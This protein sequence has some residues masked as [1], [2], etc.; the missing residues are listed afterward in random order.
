MSGVQGVVPIEETLARVDWT[1][2]PLGPPSGWPASLRTLMDTIRAAR[3]QIVLFWGPDHVALY[4]DAYAPSIGTKHPA[5]FGRPAREYWAELWDDLEPL[6]RGVY[7]TGE[8]FSARDRPF[9]IERGAEGETVYFDVSYSAARLED[10]AIG[11]VLCIV[12]E[13]TKR[14]LAERDLREREAA[15]QLRE[16]QAR[17]QA[18]QLAAIYQ[19]SPVGLAVLDADLRYVRV[20]DMLAQ[21][22]GAPAEAHV[23]RRISEMIPDLSEQAK[24]L[25]RRVLGG[26]PVWGQEV[27]GPTPGRP[28]GISVWRENWVPLRDARGTVSGIAVSCED[29]TEERLAQRAVETL[30]RVGTALAQEHDLERLV[31]LV[32]DAG[33]ELSGAAFGAFFY[34]V[35]DARGESYRLYA[36]SGVSREAFDGFPMP[37]N[38]AIFAP[39]FEGLGI[40]RSDDITRD[41][42]YGRNAP[43]KGMPE[44]H[45]PVRSYLA[46]PV[47]A[48]DGAVLGGLFFGHPDAARFTA[49]HEQ[50]LS[51]LAGQAGVAIENAR[52]L[53]RVREANEQLEKRVQA[54]TAELEEAHAVLR[55][56]QKMEA[57]GQLTGGVAHDFNNLLT[58]IV[59]NLDLICMRQ[60]VDAR[61]RRLVD[62]ALQ[63]AQK[64]SA[65]V[66]RLLAFARRQPLQPMAVDLSRLVNDMA[67]LLASTLGPQIRIVLDCPDGLP[68]ALAD[69]NQVEMALLNLSVNARDAM[70]DGGTLT[71]RVARGDVAGDQGD[72]AP[73]AYLRLS[74][75]DTGQGMDPATLARAIEPF[76]ST[77]GVGKGTGL[78]L[79][80]VHGLASQLGGALQLESHCDRGTSATLWLPVAANDQAAPHQAVSPRA[81]NG[82]G[83]VLLVDDEDAVRVTTREMLASL[84]Y[85]VVEA[86]SAPAALRLIDDGLR[87]DMLLSDHMMPDMTGTQLA[88]M[89]RERLPATQIVIMSGYADL[90]SLSPLFPHLPKPFIRADLARALQRDWEDVA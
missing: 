7:N 17:T 56:S 39:T 3:A 27:V 32:T 70:P 48:R 23:G 29:V 68:W 19:A 75:T 64:A 16:Q 87:P 20:N 57:M 80:M 74:V 55:Q 34:N 82:A 67:G 66:Q 83:L 86:P 37:R 13:T 78:G 89:L 10:G 30:N 11:G 85:E 33:V 60:D 77:K 84:G 90:G 15:L 53:Q 18:D 8:T 2:S 52:L 65:L 58:P 38:T 76:F 12:S 21:W 14:V 26:E 9:Y 44:G 73:G 42:R 50:L 40:V 45:L 1:A 36:L 22:N 51:S 25:F 81:A 63:S 79:S 31:Q 62:A 43:G 24:D 71:I 72:L 4:N 5:A 47:M 41:E 49:R 59:G 46:L 61:T 88:K 69:A 35:V 28:E 6:L 54:R